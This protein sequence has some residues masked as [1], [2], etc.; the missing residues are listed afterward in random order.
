MYKVM[1]HGL[2]RQVMVNYIN[3]SAFTEGEEEWTFPNNLI[4]KTL[5]VIGNY[6][7]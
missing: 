5:A 1:G 7:K 2:W 4:G 6:S 3:F